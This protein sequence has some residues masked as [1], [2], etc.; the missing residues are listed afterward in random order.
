M[1]H[2]KS[3]QPAPENKSYARALKHQRSFVNAGAF[4]IAIIGL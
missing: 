2:E 1:A 4:H 3:E